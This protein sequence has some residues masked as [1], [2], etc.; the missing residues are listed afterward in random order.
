MLASIAVIVA[1]LYVAKGVLVPITLA[2][3]L[4]FLL[5]P[6][7]DWLERHWL[8]RV[9]AVMVTA[10][11]G[12]TVFGGATWMAVVQVSDLAP[13]MPEYETNLKVKLQ[14]ANAYFSATLGRVTRTAQGM[15]ENLSPVELA[16]APQGTKEWPYA[17]R[18]I[19]SPASPLQ[20]F[21]SVFG[22]VLQVLGS[23]GVVIILV[24]FFLVRRDD[25]RD[26]FILLVGHGQVSLTTQ[27]LED[28]G[29]RVSRYLA[30]AFLVNAIFGTAVGVGLYLIGVPNPT[31]WGI[32]ATILRFIP[33]LGP[34]LAAAMPIGLSMAISG[35]WMAPG[36]TIGLFVVLE[37]VTNN[38]LEPWLYGKN[39]GVSAV[40]VLLAAV[41]WTW[42]WGVVGLLLAT[43]LTVCLL[44]VGK[45]VPQLSFLNTLLGDK[46]VFEPTKRVYQRLLAGDDEEAAELLDK[47]FEHAPLVEVYDTVLIPAL[48]SAETHWRRGEIEETRHTFILQTLKSMIQER[49]ER[50]QEP[51]QQAGNE[52]VED[53]ETGSGIADRAALPG[54]CVLCI[55]AHGEADELAAMMLA[56][57]VDI[58]GCVVETVPAAAMGAAS[59]LVE[60]VG[61]RKA[62]VVCISAVPPAAVTHARRLRMRLRR[63]FPELNLVV[64]LWSA[65]RDLNEAKER[66]GSDLKTQIVATL[67]DAQAQIR[68]FVA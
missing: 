64:G 40:A 7:C 18:I 50:K 36:L 35:D 65:P 59:E 68:R 8:G 27:M 3:L 55:P 49:G 44:V 17:V 21:G 46:P 48:V 29:T 31:L 39:T 56:Q 61:Q 28:A 53:A 32:L 12:F 54:I 26:R 11:V 24:V 66:I 2:V 57:I 6:V 62:D 63:R 67:A 43:P 47:Y 37:L 45:H 10:L 5:S 20:V 33:Y 41:F 15:S 1:A 38:A 60:Y 23:V 16:Q 14:S 42:L 51:Q 22:T 9:P 19:S 58:R 25:L 34:W 4:S 30:A 52:E 13:R